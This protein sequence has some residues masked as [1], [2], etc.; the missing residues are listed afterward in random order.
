MKNLVSSLKKTYGSTFGRCATC[1]RQS[2][3]AALAMWGAYCVG[4]WA[5]PVLP[6]LSLV[7]AAA[8]VLTLLWVLH[9]ATFAV[10]QAAE[11]HRSDADGPMSGLHAPSRRRLLGVMVRAGTVTAAA[12][13]PLLV[14]TSRSFA[15]C[16]QCTVNSDCGSANS[17]WCCKNTAPVNAGYVCNECKKC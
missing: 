6:G 17:G 12:S 11:I 1:M 10:R 7:A 14:W 5:W 13:V 8:G 9:V 4:V 2:M 3:A 15:F 16:G